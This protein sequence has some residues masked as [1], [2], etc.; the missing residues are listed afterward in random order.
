MEV[1]HKFGFS[2]DGKRVLV[3]WTFIYSIEEIEQLLQGLQKAVTDAKR[4]RGP[5]IIIPKGPIL[6]NKN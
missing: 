5:D 1:D 3:Q 2:D 6:P 4:K